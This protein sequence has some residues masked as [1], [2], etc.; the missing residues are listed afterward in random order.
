MSQGI[1]S[2]AN[3]LA[4]YG[5][6]GDTMVAHINPQEAAMLKRMGGSGTINP[7]TGLPEFGF[8]SKAWRTVYDP[9]A[10]AAYRQQLI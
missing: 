10:K 8:L 7:V 4:Q 9:I 1:K 2:L 3:N 5:R 6:N